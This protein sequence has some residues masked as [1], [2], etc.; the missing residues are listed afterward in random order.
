MRTF[1]NKD[2]MRRDWVVETWYEK[3]MYVI[4]VAW[5]AFM[6]LAFLVGFIQAL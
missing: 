1:F 2:E 5:T 6:A 3:T 4:G